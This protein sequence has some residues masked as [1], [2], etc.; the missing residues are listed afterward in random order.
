[1]TEKNQSIDINNHDISKLWLNCRN[2]VM[3]ASQLHFVL[4]PISA[5]LSK[6]ENIS[7]RDMFN[8]NILNARYI[9]MFN[10]NLLHAKHI[11][12][13]VFNEDTK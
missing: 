3:I 1:M 8:K 4:S 11:D 2:S 12:K 5:F 6:Y 9:D 13:D 10:K 7:S